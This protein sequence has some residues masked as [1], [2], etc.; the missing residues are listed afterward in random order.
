VGIR[1]VREDKREFDGGINMHMQEATTELLEKWKAIWQE[2]KDRLIPNRKSGAEIVA[3]LSDRYLLIEIHDDTALRV[4]SEN[5]MYN[6][7]LASKIP[8]GSAPSPKAYFV[9]SSA[10]GKTLYEKQDEVFK[11]IKIFVGVD[12]V[13]GFYCVEGSSLLWDE[14]CAFQGLDEMDI[15]NPYCV[16]EYISCLKR[17]CLLDEAMDTSG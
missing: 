17:L 13:S 6:E 2:Y 3:Y 11:G 10:N 4:I 16:A 14:L 9:E 5:V 1:G 12:L 15:Q 8:F 7:L